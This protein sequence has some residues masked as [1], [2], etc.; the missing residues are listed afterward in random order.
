MVALDTNLLIYACDKANPH[1]QATAIELIKT[2]TNGVLLWQV[3]CEFVAASR[4]LSSQGFTS[5]DAWE[6][7]ADYL[8]LFPLVLPA[9][10]VFERARLLHTRDGWS[11]WDAM[12]VAACLE[13][14]VTRL[15]SED[16]PGRPV[17]GPLEIINPFA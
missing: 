13:C 2:A 15:Y 6:R 9:A 1:R 3:A 12:I 5:A 17:P 11:F 10:G 7:L 14:G 4:K 8:A 16:L